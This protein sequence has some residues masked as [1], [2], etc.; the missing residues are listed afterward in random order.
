MDTAVILCA[1]L[2]RRMQGFPE[3]LPKQLIKVAGREILYR[4]IKLLKDRGV[5][6]FIFVVNETNRKP[7]E[8]FVKKLRINYKVVL[9][10]DPERENGYSLYLA[11]DHV[12]DRFV[13]TMGDHIY[14]EEFIEKAL[15]GEGLIVDDLALYTDRE[16]AT[17]VLCKEGRVEDIGKKLR[18]FNGY[19]TGFFILGESIFETAERLINER[20]KITLSE[21][22]KSAKVRCTLVSGE[23]WTDV[24]TP[25][26]VERAKRELLRASVKG[27]GDGF[28]S[29]NLNRR[30][31][32]WL[33]EKLVDRITPNQA[34]WLTFLV[35]VFSS[36]IALFSPTLGGL[37]YQLSSMMDGIDGEIA[38]ASMRTTKFGGYLDSVLDRYADFLFLSALA[39]WLKPPANFLL[40]VLLALF[41][42]L[43]VSYTTERFRGA[44]CEDAYGVIKQLRFL[45]GK[46]DERVFLIM[47]F[48]LFGWIS[49]LFV[50][51]A[52]LTNLRVALTLYLVWKEKGRE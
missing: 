23:F 43:M 3:H 19:D 2:A 13:L 44:Y 4:T 28:V 21:I 27:V 17:K 41:G 52:V 30:F 32:L 33:S 48:C 7:I 45:L 12:K 34:T 16:E 35:A 39:L 11:K 10:P 37:L 14:S 15:E 8:E 47:V 40:W 36:L 6:N 9:N 5:I 18:D 38:R 26:D 50:V 24:D 42:T 46:R 1:G 31:S 22:V 29:R 20:E 49:A 51:L 25:Q